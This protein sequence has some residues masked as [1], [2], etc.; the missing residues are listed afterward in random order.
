MSLGLVNLPR[1]TPSQVFSYAKFRSLSVRDGDSGSRKNRICPVYGDF[2]DVDVVA[3]EWRTEP[4]DEQIPVPL[5][6]KVFH[7]C[8]S[9]KMFAA[10]PDLPASRDLYNS[11]IFVELSEPAFFAGRRLVQKLFPRT[12]RWTKGPRNRFLKWILRPF[13]KGTRWLE[14]A[15]RDNVQHE[16]GNV[17]ARPVDKRR[18]TYQGR[19][20]CPNIPFSEF[21][22][23]LQEWDE[24]EYYANPVMKQNC[25]E[26]AR[27]ALKWA[28]WQSFPRCRTSAHDL[29][30]ETSEEF[31]CIE[32][33]WCNQ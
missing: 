13:T 29:L 33:F 6:A 32:S 1:G 23:I 21:Q 27:E 28:E 3:V 25:N 14:C 9:K 8:S 2:P 10:R 15:F 30:M 5:L 22:A 4:M 24:R 7:W 12:G 19:R 11:T 20:I 17:V 26:F 31:N 16:G 18:G